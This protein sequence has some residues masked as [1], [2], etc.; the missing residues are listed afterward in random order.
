M[1]RYM[2][3]LRIFYQ[4]EVDRKKFKIA[5]SI[6]LNKTQTFNNISVIFIS[7]WLNESDSSET[8]DRIETNSITC[9][10]NKKKKIFQNHTSNRALIVN[11]GAK[12][13]CMEYKKEIFEKERQLMYE[14]CKIECVG[15]N[16]K[17]PFKFDICSNT[18]ETYEIPCQMFCDKSFKNVNLRIKYFGRCDDPNKIWNLIWR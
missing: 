12:P 2:Y 11:M 6:Q 17:M 16:E 7:K 8:Y 9:Y 18:G 4:V 14:S 13:S 3:G 15:V 10:Q 1:M 5:M